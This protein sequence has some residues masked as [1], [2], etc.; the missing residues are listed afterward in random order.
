MKIHSRRL[1][2]ATCLAGL[3]FAQHGQDMSFETGP[4]PIGTK[5]WPA[6]R[7]PT[8]HRAPRK[9]HVLGLGILVDGEPGA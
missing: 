2:F 8:M 3:L 7:Q 5:P 4:S 6:A 9:S 1:S